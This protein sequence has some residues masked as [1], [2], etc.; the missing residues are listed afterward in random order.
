MKPYIHCKN[1]VRRFGGKPED[2]QEI[3]DFF[4]Q[5]KAHVADMRHRAILHNSFGIFL[6]EQVFGTYITNSDGK[7]VQVRDVGE[8][9]VL[10]DMGFIPSV[11][12]WMDHMGKPDWMGGLKKKK[13][14]VPYD[15]QED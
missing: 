1:S 14:F 15:R 4:D 2:Y 11:Q 7:K 9:H 13:K 5:T 3:H 12:N 8:Q 6:A 10:E